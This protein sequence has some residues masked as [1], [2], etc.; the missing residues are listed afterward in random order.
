MPKSIARIRVLKYRTINSYFKIVVLFF[1]KIVPLRRR[2]TLVAI[3][4]STQSTVQERSCVSHDVSNV[5]SQGPA[6]GSARG[7]CRRR[8]LRCPNSAPPGASC[9][10]S[11]VR[12]RRP[13]RPAAA[14]ADLETA[15]LAVIIR[16][17]NSSR[18]S[19]HRRA[20]HHAEDVPRGRGRLPL[21]ELLLLAP[22]NRSAAP[23]SLPPRGRGW[24]LG[25]TAR[26]HW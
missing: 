20:S 21:R 23:G 15:P 4:N 9:A 10:R 16:A 18:T 5:C 6:A 11:A 25:L 1:K 14:L 24:P 17:Q 7:A 2:S 22:Q 19:T 8:L 3:I 12:D 26:P 13:A